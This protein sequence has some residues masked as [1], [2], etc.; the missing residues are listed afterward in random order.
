MT[1]QTKTKR[2]DW[3]YIKKSKHTS[4][5]KEEGKKEYFTIM[6]MWPFSHK[7]NEYFK[8]SLNAAKWQLWPKKCQALASEHNDI[9]KYVQWTFGHN[10]ATANIC[11]EIKIPKGA[12]F[13]LH[14]HRTIWIIQLLHCSCF[15]VC[16]FHPFC[17]CFFLLK[18]F[19]HS[20]S[21]KFDVLFSRL[22]WLY[23]F[24][25]R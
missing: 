4:Y 16:L 22:Q 23:S 17:K 6:I 11:Q 10:Y 2:E 20:R 24:F 1:E 19:T 18:Y 3:G 5:E 25:W 14:F 8:M 21:S 12:Y 7:I 13:Y 9:S 15:A